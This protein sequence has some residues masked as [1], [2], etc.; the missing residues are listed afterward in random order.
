M[1]VVPFN[2]WTKRGRWFPT[3][4]RSSAPAAAAVVHHSVTRPTGSAL[5]EV[6]AVE[7]VIYQRRIKSLFSMIAYCWLIHPDGTIY[8]G[9]GSTWRNGANRN[10]RQRVL[11]WISNKILS[12]SNTVSVCLIGDYRTND[13]TDAQRQA[14]WWLINDLERRGVLASATA[15][16]GHGELSYTE[17][18]SRA[19]DQ[20]QAGETLITP[21]TETPIT[22]T[23][24]G[25]NVELWIDT[26]GRHNGEA[27]L[28][29]GEVP[30]DLTNSPYRETHEREMAAA[31]KLYRFTNTGDYVRLTYPSH[32]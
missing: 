32:F 4:R 28:I 3:P 7:E 5:A 25:P 13:V 18:P 1:R 15:V 10:T 2:N 14:F 6:R 30:L 9:R 23:K 26:G 11:S 19:L 17:C 8:E 27:W 24:G 22:H 12:N 29:G 20:L 21:P 16:V 31:G